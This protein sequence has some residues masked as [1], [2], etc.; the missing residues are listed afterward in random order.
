M[1]IHFDYRLA[2]Q[3]LEAGVDCL[4]PLQALAGN[5]DAERLS[6][7]FRGKIAFLGGGNMAEQFRSVE[8]RFG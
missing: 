3:C 5:M 1:D 2:L 4:H 7:E 8:G 6:S